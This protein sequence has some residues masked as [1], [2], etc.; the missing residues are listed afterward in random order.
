MDLYLFWVFIVNLV[1]PTFYEMECFIL[2][3]NINVEFII[4]F[5]KKRKS[6][7]FLGIVMY[8]LFPLFSVVRS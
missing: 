8:V 1:L 4:L 2:L 7:L 5:P 6:S 3:N